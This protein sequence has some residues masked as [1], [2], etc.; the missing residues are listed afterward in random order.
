[1][2]DCRP[3]Y[4]T[5]VCGVRTHT[6]KLLDIYSIDMSETTAQTDVESISE[7]LE[8]DTVHVRG[9]G[10]D[11]T[12]DVAV[13]ELDAWK[14]T[15]VARLE[16]TDGHT[17]TLTDTGGGPLSDDGISANGRVVNVERVN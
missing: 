1:M 4:C 16:P 10:L 2:G 11:V 9:N 14:D 8:G 5:V 17:W 7:L 12:A 13:I 15:M 6:T 3:D